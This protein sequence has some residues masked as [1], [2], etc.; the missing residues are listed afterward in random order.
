MP[1]AD[2][3]YYSAGAAIGNRLYVVGGYAA[4]GTI[5]ATNNEYNTGVYYLFRKN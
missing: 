1:A 3:R 2:A 5:L 4:S